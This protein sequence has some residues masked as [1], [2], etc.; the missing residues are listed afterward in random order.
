MSP[1]Q[2]NERR[3]NIIIF[4]STIKDVWFHAR[5]YCEAPSVSSIH[6][7]FGLTSSY[8]ILEHNS[9]F[10]MFYFSVVSFVNTSAIYDPIF[11][12]I[13][14]FPTSPGISKS[15]PESLIPASKVFSSQS[16]FVK[17]HYQSDLSNIKKLHFICWV[18]KIKSLD[19]TC[20]IIDIF[21]NSPKG[22]LRLV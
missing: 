11:T 8:S 21:A 9:L 7:V 1:F 17:R 5:S 18:D 16:M 14:I 13:I 15:C 4:S 12:K 20:K 3:F 22:F 2:K 19:S 10:Y 6:S